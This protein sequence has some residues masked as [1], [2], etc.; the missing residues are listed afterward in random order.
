MDQLRGIT[1]ST[2]RPALVKYNN[3]Q[4]LRAVAAGFVA[5]YHSQVYLNMFVG[6]SA[7]ASLFSS[8]QLGFH[9]V[10]IF[11]AISGFLMADFVQRTDPWSFILHRIVRIYPPYYIC[12]GRLDSTLVFYAMEA[13]N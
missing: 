9:G 6:P 11:F 8:K 10:I 5:I 7:Y 2:V 1:A 4:V 3:V 13:T 12:R